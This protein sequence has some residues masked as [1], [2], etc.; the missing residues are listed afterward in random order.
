MRKTFIGIAL[1]MTLLAG[2]SESEPQEPYSKTD[3]EV[4]GKDTSSSRYGSSYYLY[5]SYPKGENGKFGID[6]I[7]VEKEEFN[8][9]KEKDKVTVYANKEGIGA[10]TKK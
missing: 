2:C 1:A 9:T 4:V 10:V 5:I 8:N 3:G 6:K 7:S